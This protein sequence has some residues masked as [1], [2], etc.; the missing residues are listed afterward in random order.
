MDDISP[1]LGHRYTLVEPLG[2]DKCRVYFWVIPDNAYKD[3]AKGSWLII[4]EPLLAKRAMDTV[5][6]GEMR[7]LVERNGHVLQVMSRGGEFCTDTLPRTPSD[8]DG[9]VDGYQ[10]YE[11]TDWQRTLTR[12]LF[13]MPPHVWR[14]SINKL[15]LGKLIEGIKWRWLG[16]AFVGCVAAYLAMTS[17]FLVWR[18]GAVEAQL[19][20][21]R[22]QLND[23][24]ALQHQLENHQAFVAV[25]QD[26]VNTFQPSS[27]LWRVVLSL[28]DKQD[29]QIQSIAVENGQVSM[30]TKSDKV[31][32]LLKALSTIPGIIEPQMASPVLQV[33]GGEIVTLT[34]RVNDD[35]VWSSDA[36]GDGA[37]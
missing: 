33:R 20:E 8:M 14:Q 30:R 23:V 17:A 6:T 13:H 34:F 26:S 18:Q 19:S 28:L 31:S 37:E 35:Q 32:D 7:W 5:A 36:G 4:P 21:Q 22:E 12:Q 10:T 11:Q 15:R 29:V 1:V 25:L 9:K 16:A 24:F 2:L 3:A 27:A